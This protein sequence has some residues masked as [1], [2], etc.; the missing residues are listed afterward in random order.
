MA[1]NYLT[2]AK[3]GQHPAMQ[4]LRLQEPLHFLLQAAVA[5]SAK[6]DGNHEIAS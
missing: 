2:R 6:R 1:K 4:S 5:R 3:R